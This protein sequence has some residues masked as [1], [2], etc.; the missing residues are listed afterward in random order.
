MQATDADHGA[1]ALVEYFIQKGGYDDFTIANDTGI[2]SVS[3]KLDYDRRNTYNMEVLAIDHGEPSHT[4][5]TTLTVNVI[6]TNDKLPYFV[7]TTQT[8]G[9]R[10]ILSF[11]QL[12]I[13]KEL[14]YFSTF[15]K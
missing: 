2:V 4:G 13:K 5:S 3:S 12:L 7:P 1:N 15:F 8:V 14:N 6:N 10:R 9:V 11:F